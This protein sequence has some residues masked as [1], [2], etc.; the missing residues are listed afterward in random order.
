MEAR[1]PGF[2]AAAGYEL[3]VIEYSPAMRW[4][5]AFESEIIELAEKKSGREIKDR[6][7]FFEMDNITCHLDG[8][9]ACDG[10]G[11]TEFEIPAPAFACCPDEQRPII[12]EGKTTSLQ[13]FR[14]HFGEPG[15]D[16]IPIEYM[17]QVQHQMICTGAEKAIVSVLVFPRRAEEWE[18]M[19]WEIKE[20]HEGY[21]LE[22]ADNKG[23]QYEPYNW[24]NAL[25]QMGFFHQY[26]VNA[27]PELQSLMLEKYS[28]FWNNHVLTGTPP[29]PVSYDDIKALYREPVGTIIADE[30]I[31]RLMSEYKQIGAEISPTGSLGKRREQIKV[32]ILKYMADKN[33]VAMDEDSADK[34]ILR[35]EQGKKIGSYGKTEKGIFIFR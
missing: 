1:N 4:G 29:E 11:N 25:D 35:D 31:T 13:Y 22:R 15:T 19:G 3:P 23:W 9:Y 16:K 28:A 26:P 30:R 33:G 6:E 5:Y 34:W 10:C 32:E 27:H 14:E 8:V 7:K 2:C 18:S 12:H 21:K 20:Y 17:C 24:A